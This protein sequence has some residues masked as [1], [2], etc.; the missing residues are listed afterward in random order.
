[1]FTKEI[2]LN[3]IF[4]GTSK[5]N[6]TAVQKTSTP[7]FKENCRG[8][9][10]SKSGLCVI[11][12]DGA[13]YF[14][15]T[16]YGKPNGKGI[17]NWNNGSIF[18]GEFKNGNKEGYGSFIWE[19]GTYFQGFIDATKNISYGIIFVNDLSK[20]SIYIGGVQTKSIAK[21]EGY[22]SHYYYKP[23]VQHDITSEPIRIVDA[24]FENNISKGKCFITTSVS[25]KGYC[26]G[27]SPSDYNFKDV[28]TNYY[29]EL[30]EGIE[31]STILAVKYF[32]EAEKI[33]NET[34]QV[35]FGEDIME[36][37]EKKKEE[38]KIVEKTQPQ[39]QLEP[40]EEQYVA[41]KNANVRQEP[42]V[43]SPVVTTIPKDTTVYVAGKVKGENWLAIEE[44][45]GIIGYSF[46][47]LFVTKQE[48]AQQQDDLKKQL[49][50]IADSMKEKEPE[51]FGSGT[52]FYVTET[53]H[54]VT[55]Q[56]V[57]HGCEYM[58]LNDEQL[59]VIKNDLVN[60]LAILKSEKSAPNFLRISRKITPMKGEDILVLGYPYGKL[61]SSESKVTKGIVS[62]LQGLGNNYS[63]FQIDAAI[64]PGNSGG[65]VFDS[66]GALVGITVATADYKFYEENFKSLP[67][68]MNFAI[69][70]NMLENFLSSVG[71]AYDKINVLEGKSQPEIVQAIDKAT[72]Y[73]ECWS[74]EE[75]VADA[76]RGVNVLVDT[77]RA[78]RAKNN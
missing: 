31:K 47:T 17:M 3:Q 15:D 58:L 40:I 45:S 71:I 78:E 76:K 77:V 6:A 28:Y 41:I 50:E 38:K 55:N 27:N 53:G 13:V 32:E 57:T 20:P 34:Y 2:T 59:K 24:F 54:V 25:N 10:T 67:Q 37:E 36:K 64:Q 1:V 62:A 60:D 18:I 46:G 29:V 42:Y 49:Q 52:G 26:N 33:A 16:K 21:R 66:E 39:I 74:T 35:A 14:G 68:N 4:S 23:G 65:P 69:K 63:Q 48:F 8:L 75:T 72:V 12:Y 7:N 56:H 11:E 9:G 73:L 70:S 5:V 61:T 30:E 51:F 43:G 22:G 44:E 19:D